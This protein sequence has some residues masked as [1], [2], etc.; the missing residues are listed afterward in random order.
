MFLTPVSE[1]EIIT[2]ISSF[3]NSSAG[4]DEISSHIVKST[5]HL[6]I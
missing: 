6:F 5:V 4:W 2:I 3:K 1:E